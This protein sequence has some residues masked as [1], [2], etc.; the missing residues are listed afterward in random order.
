[1]LDSEARQALHLFEMWIEPQLAE[2]GDLGGMT[3]WGGKLVGA[4][5]R[6]AGILHMASLASSPA[7]WD[8]PISYATVTAAILLGSYLIP[9][10]KAAFAAMGAD[11]NVENAKAILRW[12]QH[13]PAPQFTKR[14]VHQGM[15]G[16][17]KR[18]EELEAPLRLLISH[19]FIRQ[20]SEAA[21]QGAGRKASPQFAVN[22]LW[23]ADWSKGNSEYCEDSEK[24]KP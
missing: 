14:E 19:G 22:P 13:K 23:I 20:I 16:R 18:V 17:F 12:I 5:C 2:F 21:R 6:I 24:R 15:R 9:H 3:D 8:V 1:M 7:P 10:A 4:V 11:A